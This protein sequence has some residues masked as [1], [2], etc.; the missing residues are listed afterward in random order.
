MIFCFHY[1]INC[2]LKR[3][4]QRNMGKQGPNLKKMDLKKIHLE[5]IFPTFVLDSLGG[6]IL[7]KPSHVFF[8]AISFLFEYLL[9]EPPIM[10]EL[11]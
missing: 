1:K 11:S 7:L 3:F 9:E 4:G 5:G 10:P 2:L 8:K 6:V